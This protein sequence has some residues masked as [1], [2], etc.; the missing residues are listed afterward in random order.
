MSDTT[1]AGFQVVQAMPGFPRIGCRVQVTCK[2]QP[3]DWPY[4]GQI[5]EVLGY[6]LPHGF[7]VV[8]IEGDEVLLHPESIEPLR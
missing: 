6:S 5:G 7:A 8:S 4:Q 1:P 2:H 3:L